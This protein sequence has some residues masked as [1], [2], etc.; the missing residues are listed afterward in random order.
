MV[1]GRRMNHKIMGDDNTTNSAT[2]WTVTIDMTLTSHNDAAEH[3]RSSRANWISRHH[4]NYILPLFRTAPYDN[5]A[6]I[7]FAE[8]CRCVHGT[9]SLGGA[10]SDA[11]KTFCHP[12]AKIFNPLRDV[13]IGAAEIVIVRRADSQSIVIRTERAGVILLQ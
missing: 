7:E 11:F 6:R 4:A 5:L 12:T 1:P 2:A 9:S 3:P 8:S 13:R 10:I